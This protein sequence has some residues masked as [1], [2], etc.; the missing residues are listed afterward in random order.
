MFQEFL[1]ALCF[2]SSNLGLYFLL[3]SCAPSWKGLGNTLPNLVL[4]PNPRSSMEFWTWS[5]F[6]FDLEYRASN[7][8][9]KEEEPCEADEP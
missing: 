9:G 1:L 6:Q 8:V 5:G 2:C 7:T 3:D 4:K